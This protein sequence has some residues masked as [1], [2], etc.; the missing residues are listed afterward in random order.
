MDR[1]GINFIF[2]VFVSLLLLETVY[3]SSGLF[4]PG[5]TGGP[6]EAY[7]ESITGDVFY[8]GQKDARLEITEIDTYW[9]LEKVDIAF[10]RYT[11]GSEK[12]T[13]IKVSPDIVW[14]LGQPYPQV[15]DDFSASEIGQT[16]NYFIK[17]VFNYVAAEN[18]PP[19]EVE[20]PVTKQAAP[21]KAWGEIKRDTLWDGDLELTGTVTVAAEATLTINAP[22]R[23]TSS[24]DKFFTVYG[25]LL[26]DGVVFTNSGAFSTQITFRKLLSLKNCT[27]TDNE[28]LCVTNSGTSTE[29]VFQG[30]SGGSTEYPG[31]I[32]LVRPLAAATYMTGNS[33]PGLDL[34]VSSQQKIIAIDHN[35]FRIV[36]VGNYD[37]GTTVTIEKNSVSDMNLNNAPGVVVRENTV[38]NLLKVEHFNG[39]GG[40]I[41]ENN[42]IHRCEVYDCHQHEREGIHIRNNSGIQSISMN[43]VTGVSVNDNV[44]DMYEATPHVITIQ[45]GGYNVIQNNIIQQSNMTGTRWG[46]IVLGLGGSDKD[47]IPLATDNQILGNRIVNFYYGIGLGSAGRNTISGN[48]LIGNVKSILLGPYYRYSSDRQV[49]GTA[50]PKENR[51]WN[52]V[53]GPPNL[54]WNGVN[55]QIDAP[56]EELQNTW[57]V[58]KA[59]GANLVGGGFL[60]GNAWSDYEDRYEEQDEDNDEIWDDPYIID[61]R[62]QDNLPLVMPVGLTLSEGH[63][64]PTNVFEFYG[65]ESEED[66]TKGREKVVAAHVTLTANSREAWN[67]TGLTFSTSGT[68]NEKEDILRARLYKDSVGGTL[69]GEEVFDQDNGSLAFNLNPAINIIANQSAA[70]ILVYDFRPEQAFPCNDYSAVI[71]TDGIEAAPAQSQEGKLFPLNGSVQGF[72]RVKPGLLVKKEGDNQYGEAKDPAINKPLA[73][74]LKTKITWQHPA[75]V[76]HVEYKIVSN[77]EFGAFLQNGKD[78]NKLLSEIAPNEEGYAEEIM[79]LGTKKGLKNPYLVEMVLVSKG[80]QCEPGPEPPFFTAWGLGVELEATSQYDNPSDTNTFGTFLS[81]IQVDNKFTLTIMDMAPAPP[82]CNIKEV[83]FTL[84]GNTVVGTEVTQ[85]QKYEAVFDMAAFERTQKLI[86]TIRM[87]DSQGAK[88]EQQEEYDVKALRIP[89]WV[90]TVTNI[91]ESVTKEFSAEE[92]GTYILTF[93]YPT[94]FIWSDYVPESVGLLGGLRNDLDIEFIASARYR[95]NET[96]TFEALLTGQPIILGKEFDMD[97]SLSGEF[98]ANF[99]FQRGTGNIGSS[100]SFDLPSKGYSRTF[101]VY[102]VPVT[103]AVDL[104]G[105]VTIFV[106][107]SAILNRQLEFEEIIVAPGTTVTG[108]ITISLAAVFGLAKIAATGSPTVTMEIELKYTSLSGTETVWRGEVVVPITVMGSIFWGLGSATLCE[109]QLGPWNFG[110]GSAPQ[111]YRPLSVTYP[112]SPRLLSTSDLAVDGTG[113]KMSVWIGDTQSDESAPP[114]PDVF[115]RFDAGSGW[116]EPKPIIGEASPNGEW[117]TDPRAVFMKDGTAL[118]CWTVNDGDKTLNDLNAILAAQDIACS[119]WNGTTWSAPVKVIDDAEADG[120]AALSYFATDKTMAVW[121]HN[122]DPAKKFDARTAW[123]LM[124]SIYDA[125]ANKG[126]GGFATPQDVPGTAEGGADQMPAVAADGAGNA[127]L[128]WARDEDGNFHTELGAVAN[129]TNV[130][131]SNPDSHIMWSLWSGSAWSVPGVLATGFNATRLSP[132]LTPAPDGQFLAVWAETEPGKPTRLMY[133]VWSV[134]GWSTPGIVAESGQFMEE[135]KSV[136]DVSGKITVIW[137]GYGAGGKGA[138][139]FSTGTMATE[140][141][142]TEPQRITHDDTIQWQPRIVV[143]ENNKVVASWSGYDAETG[144][145]SSG[146]GLTGGVNIV[147]PDPGTAALTGTYSDR[148]VDMDTDN[149][150]ESLEVSV[151]INIIT[152]GDYKIQADLCKGDRF[153]AS[154]DTAAGDLTVG[155]HLVLLLFP[156]SIISD[157]GLDGPYILKNLLVLDCNDSPVQTA[158]ENIAYTTTGAYGAAG[159][160]SGPLSL[161]ND[162]YLGTSSRA[163]ITVTDSRA[164]TD[165]GSVQTVSAGISTT[166]DPGGFTL[167]LVETGPDTGIFQGDAGF[168]LFGSS[169]ELKKIQVA[170]HDTIHVSYSDAN[171]GYLFT[172]RALWTCAGFGDVNGDGIIDLSDAILTIQFGARIA[173]TDMEITRA[174]D[175]NGDER[176]GIEEAI[177]I[178]Q[179]MAGLR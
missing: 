69:L 81:T 67:V 26:A 166:M 73:I 22:A 152:A 61:N 27:F 103:A 165:A 121:M 113:R 143:D 72:I 84:G 125:T 40:A 131:A 19:Q 140:I 63:L 9:T 4:L 11:E 127:M 167:V 50:Y 13:A 60:G 174:A 154:V 23:I 111:A 43:Q 129:G 117:E 35:T 95:V 87:E 1:S 42:T 17:A 118:A 16:Y 161:D 41:I 68:G 175:V 49:T 120:T 62:N 173:T 46:G 172:R 158:F 5:M 163:V 119:T 153:I 89:S 100:F 58:E 109:T 44:M 94:N 134:T 116:S 59:A 123:K 135:P 107:G 21:G 8:V 10:W 104:S 54:L 24:G 3:I 114:D 176:I 56:S 39:T 145:A 106:K 34:A 179:L 132:S 76:D 162:T 133:A 28:R 38:D 57:N 150:Y 115:F 160:V 75:T 7:A 53:V 30:N 96:S 137:R 92:G 159:F 108:N 85:N 148:G 2:R 33:I 90:D 65:L 169:I 25:N 45:E 156:G 142:W 93:N 55:I 86:I 78:E 12:S 98:D 20:G 101:F 122:A 130:D 141:T 110:S 177:Y 146:T 37:E 48:S 15:Y 71:S 155:N 105:N 32:N 157:L 82:D 52:N 36:T 80:D 128:I 136:V 144:E 124:Y 171:H 164:N 149:I 66:Y 64:N 147:R 31:Y 29:L 138:L 47:G 18:R 178:M 151:G 139:F 74:P 77:P 126:A 51:I 70:M 91:S 112:G 168:S 88:S 14:T 6:A 83:L 97:G 79:T 170:D 102:G 99:A